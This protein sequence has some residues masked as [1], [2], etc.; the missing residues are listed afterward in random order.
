[1]LSHAGVPSTV[2]GASGVAPTKIAQVYTVLV[3][4]TCAVQPSAVVAMVGPVTP[5]LAEYIEP[6]L[7]V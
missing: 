6:R 5:A 4:P 2:A 3:C 7:V 1:M